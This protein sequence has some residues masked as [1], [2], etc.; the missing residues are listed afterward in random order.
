[1]SIY[2]SVYIIT[3]T[4][5]NSRLELLLNQEVENLTN[6]YEVTKDRYNV[7]SKII[8]QEVFNSERVLELF[9]NAKNTNDENERDIFRTM[10]YKE[11]LP[12]FENLRE[13]GVNIIHFA[14]RDNKSFLRVHDKDMY[15][16]D[17][18]LSRP[19]I[20]HVNK[21]KEPI[22]G[23]EQDKQMH[24]FRNIFPLFYNYKF[25]GSAEVSFSSQSMQKAMLELHN[26]YTN[27]IIKKNLLDSNAYKNNF[28]TNYIQS[29]EHK[30]FI[31]LNIKSNKK[32]IDVK[33]ILSDKKLKADIVENIKH[34]NSFSLYTHYLDDSYIVSFLPIKDIK[35][36]KTLAYLVSY[37]KS[38]Y[39]YDM[40]HEYIILN[41]VAFFGFLILFVVV[42]FNIKQ[43]VNLEEIVKKR[44]QELENEK[45]VAQNA[46]K[47][48]SQF[49]ANMSH[50]IRTPMNGILGISHLLFK[51]KL[52]ENQ[53]NY[54][55]K[56]DNSAKSLLNIINDILDLSKIEAGK[57]T[58]ESV[59][60]NLKKAISQTLAPLEIIANQKHI[61]IT[62]D[63]AKNVG[64]FFIG[65]SLRISQVLTNLIGNAIKFTNEEGK[66]SI[67][68]VKIK[69]SVYRFKIED[70]GIGLN[71]N[72]Q[73]KLFKLFSQADNSTTRK[74]GGTGLGLAISKE[75]VEL[76]GGTIWVESQEGLGSSFIFEIKLKEIDP[77]K[78]KDEIKK[79]EHD[80]EFIKAKKI[81]I[82]ED[83]TTNQLVLLG[84]LEDYVEE[85]DVAK[86]GKEAVEMFE[87]GKYEL[88]F[89][90]LQMPVM[91]GYEATKIIREIDKEIPII[92]LT[93]NAMQEEIQKTKSLGMNTH[94]TK[95]IDLEKFFHTLDKYINQNAR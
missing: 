78:P 6:S 43:R 26:T 68:V 64:D 62:T 15:N 24:A 13:T 41:S 19:S 48:K 52:S 93:A 70:S 74:Y 79:I 17:L 3:T 69:D 45:T 47:T 84:L 94:L 67:Y 71:E 88:I 57:F 44:T 1:M 38:K 42:Y 50:E 81:L 21:T 16:D 9:Y 75:L 76:M 28:Y 90:D 83:N 77:P 25:I 82:V 63:Y 65:D 72:E 20:A 23:F 8:N 59:E 73:K 61:K 22:S 27:F 10:L 49:L 5:K 31:F 32:N 95:P 89:M 86:N 36:K 40:T 53:K 34:Q 54:L 46:T 55:T 80:K 51:T 7:I 14:F 4:D 30:D 18:S 56:I 29:I 12:H 58:I 39:I 37:K 2:F 92:A 87:K 33:N 60:F 91:D 85:I 35:E 11:L 66:I